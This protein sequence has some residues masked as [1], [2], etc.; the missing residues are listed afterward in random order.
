MENAVLSEK[1]QIVIP[2]G[3]REVLQLKP[4][5]ELAVWLEGNDIHLTPL[6]RIKDPIK[7]MS[8]LSKRRIRISVKEIEREIEGM[9]E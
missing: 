2:K 3:V 6:K 4:K 7:V 1:F 8:S 5:Q 9:Y